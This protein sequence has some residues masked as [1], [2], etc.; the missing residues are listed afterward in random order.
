MGSCLC[1]QS[2]PDQGHNA[3]YTDNPKPVQIPDPLKQEMEMEQDRYELLQGL[4]RGAY[5]F[6]ALANDNQSN[7]QV[8]I[9]CVIRQSFAGDDAE[10]HWNE[11]KVRI[12]R[13]ILYHKMLTGHP[14]IISIKEIFMLSSYFCIVM[15]YAQGSNLFNYVYSRFR[16]KDPVT[17]NEIRQ[18]FQQLMFAMDRI[19]TLEIV[20]R[21][22][23][24]E[25]VL[26]QVG[27][28][29]ELILKLCD[30]GFAKH[31]ERDSRP[32]SIVGSRPY[33]SP[34]VLFPHDYDQG[35]FR[36]RDIWACG[37]ILYTLC[38]GKYPFD[39]RYFKRQIDYFQ[40]IQ[41]AAF[42]FPRFPEYSCQVRRLIKR[43]LT[44]DPSQRITL[45]QVMKTSWFQKGLIQQLSVDESIKQNVQSD[46]TIISLID[47]AFAYQRVSFRDTPSE[48]LLDELV[49]L[50]QLENDSQE[51]IS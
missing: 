12:K 18:W 27:D 15:E 6:V 31:I 4:G 13:E 19:N 20:N 34:E 16:S 8:A 39:P 44:P 9:K 45:Q 32:F 2:K 36:Q 30:F 50:E 46:D 21:D 51:E 5:G 22:I 38:Y 1:T 24:L 41:A 7:E 28:Q 43:M 3:K 29:D 23:K 17:E 35:D 33:L 42:I 25:N 26:I 48:E 37:V 40:A 14:N 49:E 10:A 47:Q 11:T